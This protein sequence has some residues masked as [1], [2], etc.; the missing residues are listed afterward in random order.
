M[1]KG[2]S[3]GASTGLEMILSFFRPLMLDLLPQA[4]FKDIVECELAIEGRSISDIEP[5]VKELWQMA[6][7]SDEV[8]SSRSKP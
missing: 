8:F 7:G 6:R 2:S 3:E 1:S 5:L 4:V